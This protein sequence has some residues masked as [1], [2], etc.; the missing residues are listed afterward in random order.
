MLSW[1]KKEIRAVAE[2]HFSLEEAV[3][4]YDKI[5]REL[6]LLNF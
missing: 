6:A 4:R 5:Y 3:G 1:D 2:A